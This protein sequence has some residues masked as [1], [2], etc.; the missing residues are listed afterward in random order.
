MKKIYSL[1]T[2]FVISTSA[3]ATDYK[4]ISF[5]NTTDNALSVDYQVCEKSPNATFYCDYTSNHVLD[6]SKSG[7]FVSIRVPEDKPERSYFVNIIYVEEKHD[8]KL[9]AHSTYANQ[10]CSSD[11]RSFVLDDMKGS[12]RIGCSTVAVN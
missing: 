4:E 2:L 8:G 3:F 5:Y 11:R 6:T 7:N 12:S 10:S 1:L 9:V